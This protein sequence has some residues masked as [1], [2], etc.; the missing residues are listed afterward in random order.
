MIQIKPKLVGFITLFFGICLSMSMLFSG[1]KAPQYNMLGSYLDTSKT[2]Q[3]ATYPFKYQE[4]TIRKYD[5]VRV[6]FA[7]KN[8]NVASQLNGNNVGENLE[9]QVKTT[10]G[11]ELSGQQVDLDGY[12]HF[13]VIGKVKAEGLTKEELRLTLLELI[14]P[15]L[16]NPFV[17]VDLP[18]RGITILGEVKDPSTI[19]F[20]KE[21][22]NIF[23]TLAQVGFTTEFAD[24]SRVK[25]YRE[26]SDG[27]R[28]LAH[29]N[30]NDSG[31]L[32]SEYFYPQPDDVIYVP[33]VESKTLR[34]F[35]QTY[36]PFAT[37]VLALST[38]F[39]TLFK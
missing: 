17:L 19:V 1:C 12:L 3:L 10:D 16:Q 32:S 23:E 15:I 37:I 4:P 9:T 26:K 20:G 25:V 22:A 36:A 21:R 28:Y 38:I 13:P 34:N 7:G 39:I 31:F 30:L 18:K 14:T 11:A 8:P 29:L 24:L 6:K 27:S 35:G 5:I 2:I 33:S